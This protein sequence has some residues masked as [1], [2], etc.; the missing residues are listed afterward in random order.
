MAAPKSRPVARRPQGQAT[1][2]HCCSSSSS[3]Q[4]TQWSV[5]CCQ[6]LCVKP[7]CQVEDARGRSNVSKTENH[8]RT[9]SLPRRVAQCPKG[10]GCRAPLK[11]A[12]TRRR[13]DVT[14][15][16]PPT[17]AVSRHLCRDTSQISSPSMVTSRTTACLSSFHGS[18][19]GYTQQKNYVSNSLSY[20]V[21][22]SYSL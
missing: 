11:A 6:S 13:E 21:L 1:A 20:S 17:P 4:C 2:R 18:C 7:F 15:H 9:N 14:Q 10:Q 16:S 3:S 5:L 8:H 19:V 22:V 12:S